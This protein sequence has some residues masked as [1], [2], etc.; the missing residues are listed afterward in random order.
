MNKKELIKKLKELK[1]NETD[2]E[3]CHWDAE[4]LLLKYINNKEVTDAFD[5]LEKWYA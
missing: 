3:K 4:Q 5:D 2:I 1:T